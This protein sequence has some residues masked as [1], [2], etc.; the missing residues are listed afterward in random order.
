MAVCRSAVNRV[1]FDVGDTTAYQD[2]IVINDER[3][4]QRLECACTAE[5][6]RRRTDSTH[7][8][9]SIFV[10]LVPCDDKVLSVHCKSTDKLK[11]YK[12]HLVLF[13]LNGIDL[14]RKATRRYFKITNAFHA[15]LTQSLYFS[16]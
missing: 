14:T 7:E 13:E 16:T 4:S 11:C 8:H 10:Q 15:F 12:T 6:D 5:I 3:A 2:L 1:T 9:N